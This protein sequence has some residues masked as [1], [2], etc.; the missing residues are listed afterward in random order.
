[1]SVRDVVTDPYAVDGKLVRLIGV[2]HRSPSGDALYWHEHDAA[3]L[4]ET[5][6]VSVRLP[7]SWPAG[8]ERRG[9]YVAVEGV[10][11]ADHEQPGSDLN[12]A[13]LDT[14]HAEVR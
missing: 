9:A 10:F 13:L 3:Q 6:G 1:M 8:S 5:H 14:R 12:G 2:L 7:P 4:N 11:K